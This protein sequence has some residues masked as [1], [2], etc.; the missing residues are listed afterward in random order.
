MK[1]I[2]YFNPFYKILHCSPF[3][4]FPLWYGEKQLKALTLVYFIE[5]RILNFNRVC[6]LM[7]LSLGCNLV[8]W[9]EL[10]K[11][12]W[13]I[14]LF[15]PNTILRRLENNKAVMGMM[16]CR[17]CLIW[18]HTKTLASHRTR[19]RHVGFLFASDG[20]GKSVKMFHYHTFYSVHTTLPNYNQVRRNSAHTHTQMKFQVLP[21]SKSSF[22]VVFLQAY[23]AKRDVAKSCPRRCVQSCTNPLLHSDIT[24]VKT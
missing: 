18:R 20:I 12:L 11:Q 22:F 24:H 16:T 19:I 9:Y 8:M 17:I 21:W 5:P 7:L 10:N 23:C 13:N 14:L 4:N 6:V 1:T 15:F 3:P 2:N